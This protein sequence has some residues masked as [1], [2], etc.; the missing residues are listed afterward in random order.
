MVINQR[1]SL[2]IIVALILGTSSVIYNDILPVNVF[3]MLKCR[4]LMP[5][6]YLSNVNSKERNGMEKHSFEITYPPFSTG[7]SESI[8][9]RKV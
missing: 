7:K 5:N 4:V 3:E 6:V 9:G 2:M 1:T 8:T